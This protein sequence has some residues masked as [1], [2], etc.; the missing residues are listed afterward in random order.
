MKTTQALK[1]EVGIE[2]PLH[3]QEA[4]PEQL[5]L[6]YKLADSGH[7]YVI[8]TNLSNKAIDL[9]GVSREQ[10][11]NVRPL[12][13]SAGK[14]LHFE[15]CQFENG[16]RV[17]EY[18][19]VDF[20]CMLACEKLA[21][22]IDLPILINVKVTP[23]LARELIKENDKPFIMTGCHVM[24]GSLSLD[25]RGE[26]P[27]KNQFW[28]DDPTIEV[29]KFKNEPCVRPDTKINELIDELSNIELAKAANEN[30][31][32]KSD[33]IPVPAVTLK[34]L[35]DKALKYD[36]LIKEFDE[37]KQ[38]YREALP[39]IEKTERLSELF[40][41]GY[42]NMPPYEFL[43]KLANIMLDKEEPETFDRA[44]YRDE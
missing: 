7:R 23:D 32:E 38:A 17:T 26:P 39:Q 31:H 20:E 30:N 28:M 6:L 11:L 19:G 14:P 10:V 24:N 4:T 42:E 25:L 35:Q 36:V 33:D 1:F 16:L 40:E 44:D 8:K 13:P 29:P 15:G 5:K 34:Q 9:M 41:V 27:Q 2:L 18:N 37:M 43:G 22:E 12:P 21:D 3:D